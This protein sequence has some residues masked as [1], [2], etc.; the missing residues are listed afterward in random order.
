[1]DVYVLICCREQ[2][3]YD[4]HVVRILK[5]V[6]TTLDKVNETYEEYIKAHIAHSNVYPMVVS[7]NPDLG[8]LEKEAQHNA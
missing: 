5:C 4:C 1:M 8:F 7:R 2:H 6:E 3:I